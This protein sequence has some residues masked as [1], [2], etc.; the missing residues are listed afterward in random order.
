[1]LF[2]LDISET[3][4]LSFETYQLICICNCT[5]NAIK[6]SITDMNK[7]HFSLSRCY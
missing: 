3:K 5:C 7:I 2:F 1:M 6:M 4:T